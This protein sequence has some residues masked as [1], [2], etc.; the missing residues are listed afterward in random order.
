MS[1]ADERRE[2]FEAIGVKARLRR[3][4][5]IELRKTPEYAQARAESRARTWLHA[6][7]DS[8]ADSLYELIQTR[9]D[10]LD[11]EAGS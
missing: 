4:V 9:K 11:P 6:E 10:S 1:A 3:V 7:A 2:I 8:L 5:E